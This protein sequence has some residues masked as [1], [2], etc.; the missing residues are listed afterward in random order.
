MIS[1]AHCLFPPELA[2]P[3]HHIRPCVELEGKES[4]RGCLSQQPALYAQVPLHRFSDS[5]R[6][7]TIE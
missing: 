5:G 2:G 6:I 4:V 7:V 1:L 3:F